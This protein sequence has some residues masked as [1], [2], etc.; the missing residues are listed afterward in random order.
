MVARRSVMSVLT[1]TGIGTS[2]KGSLTMKKAMLWIRDRFIEVVVMAG[3]V[4]IIV[5]FMLGMAR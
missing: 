2:T 3:V 5:F 1:D 4:A